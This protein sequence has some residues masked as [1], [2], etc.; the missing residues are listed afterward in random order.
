MNGKGGDFHGDS[1]FERCHPCHVGLLP[2]P[3]QAAAPHDIID[4]A[5]IDS[6]PINDLL[7]Q[8]GG[9]FGGAD[10]PEGPAIGTNRGSCCR[11]NDHIILFHV[12]A[13]L[14]SIENI[15]DALCE[16]NILLIALGRKEDPVLPYWN[17]P[18]AS[19]L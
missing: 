14:L 11:N 12:C 9:K 2:I 1:R 4:Y 3:L 17:I 10:I 16:K 8:R 15:V 19:R 6:G 7:H 13:F 5:G 18:G